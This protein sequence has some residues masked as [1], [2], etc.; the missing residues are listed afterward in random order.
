MRLKFP[1]APDRCVTAD[2]FLASEADLDAEVRGLAALTSNCALFYPEL[3]KLGAAELVGLLAHE[4]VD[5]SGAVV[6]CLLYTSPSPRD[7]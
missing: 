4:N 3:V 1:E 5:I 2:S 7:S 6:S